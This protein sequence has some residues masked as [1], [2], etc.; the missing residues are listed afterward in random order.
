MGI[1]FIPFVLFQLDC[2]EVQRAFFEH[3]AEDLHG[4]FGA[5]MKQEEYSNQNVADACSLKKSALSSGHVSSQGIHALPGDYHHR[6]HCCVTLCFPGL[7]CSLFLNGI[8]S[9][10]N[11]SIQGHSNKT[12]LNHL[13]VS[14]TCEDSIKNLI[15]TCTDRKASY[16]DLSW[17]LVNGF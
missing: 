8:A 9:T 10:H 1:K 3:T 12:F 13:G 14:V 17:E 2:G 4:Q 15:R 11:F 7:L 6:F 5:L 16:K